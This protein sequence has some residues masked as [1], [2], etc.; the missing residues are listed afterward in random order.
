MRLSR[1]R[2]LKALCLALCWPALTWATTPKQSPVKLAQ[3]SPPIKLAMIEGLSGPFANTG[4]A[5]YRNLLWAVER[6]NQRGGVKLPGGARELSLV[7][8]DSKSQ[9][10]EALTA[11]R[12]FASTA[13]A[14]RALMTCSPERGIPFGKAKPL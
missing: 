6:V 4:E 13:F 5:V 12:T 8:H 11:L 1:V 2:V 14:L 9:T 3:T 10:E 7:R